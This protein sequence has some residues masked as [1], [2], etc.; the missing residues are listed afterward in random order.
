MTDFH[1]VALVTGGASGL[2][3]A[4]A[5]HL[6]STGFR[7]VVLD[8]S[9]RAASKAAEQLGVGHLSFCVDVTSEE[10]V[11]RTIAEI[12]GKC[13]RLDVAI[14]AAGIPDSFNATV[15]QD[16]DDWRRLIDVH[17]TGSYLIAR[18]A[19]RQMLRQ[20]SGAIV[21][22]SSVAGVSG[23]PRRNAYTAAKTGI[24]GLTRSLA[25]EWAQSG[26]RVNAVLPGYIETPFVEQLASEGKLD[27]DVLR[28]RTPMGRL[29]RPEDIAQAVGFLCS[30]AAAYITGIVLPVDGG[31]CAYGAAGDASVL[32]D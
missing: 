4:S 27:R 20:G 16:V 32:D 21:Q 29:G 26:V 7:V 15:D 24:I 6:A 8:R 3:Y 23:L 12:V 18:A 28:R 17:L 31:W 30:S 19:G 22:F 14:S 11:E 10:A 9:E 13:G 2:G 5:A 25:C 1:S